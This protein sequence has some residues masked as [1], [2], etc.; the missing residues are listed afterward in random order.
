MNSYANLLSWGWNVFFEQQLEF[1]NTDDLL[2]ARVIGQ[3]RDLYRLTFGDEHL[4]WAQVSGRFRHDNELDAGTFPAVGDWVLCKMEAQQERAMI[5]KVFERQACF[6]RRDPD[7]RGGPQVVA[8]NVDVVFI[9]TSMNSDLNLKRLDRYLSLAWNSGASP[10]IVLSKRDLAEDPESFIQQVEETYIGVPVHGVSVFDPAT[11]E[12]LKTYLQPGKTAVLLGSSG[13]GK[14]TLTNFFL[15][16]EIAETQGIREEDERGRHTTTSRSLYRLP[17]GALLMDTP[18]MRQLALLDEEEGVEGLFDD[19]LNLASTCRFKD[20]SHQSEPGCAIQAALEDGT[21][22]EERWESF[23]KLQREVEYQ[24]RRVD[25]QKQ[26]AERKKWKKRSQDL[27]ER[28]KE[29]G[30]GR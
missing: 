21:L 18:G 28:L 22:P 20:C 23:L 5:Q 3:E 26:S 17:E 6:S 29:K 7:K 1:L 24:E 8:A 25:K 10:V 16:E 11:C 12:V 30:R 15:G 9:V 14:S 27:Y 13:V 4:S 19:I 2:I